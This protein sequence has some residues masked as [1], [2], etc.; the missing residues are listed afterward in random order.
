M[1]RLSKFNF[2]DYIVF[3]TL[4]CTLF[5]VIVTK[6]PPG[7]GSV[8]FFWG[9]LTIITLLLFANSIYSVSPVKQLMLFGFVVMLLFNMIFWRNLS[10]WNR[11][12]FL[13]DF[14]NIF[15]YTII[16]SYY[17]RS[18]KVEN[19]YLISKISFIYIIITAIMTNIGLFFDPLIIRDSA[20]GF[21]TNVRQKEIYNLYGT[22]RYGYAQA[23][24]L[25][26]PFCFYSLK[27]NKNSNVNK[28]IMSVCIA[29]I[30]ITTLRSQVF[31]NIINLVFVFIFS[32]ISIEK[33]KSMVLLITPV[34]LIVIILPKTIYSDI[35][36]SFTRYFSEDSNTFLKLNDF[37]D[38]FIDPEI[39]MST[40]TGGRAAR[41]PLLWEAFLQSP[42]VGHS[43]LDKG[44]DIE[45]GGHLFWMNRL[46]HFGLIGFSMLVHSLYTTFKT[47]KRNII[48]NEGVYYYFLSIMSFLLFGLMKNIAGREIWAI[49]LVVIPGLYLR[50][51]R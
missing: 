48:K 34:V 43:Y 22:A 30:V 45:A 13:D 29:L 36:R 40:G 27:H 9:P 42:I 18:K 10:D 33:R 14:Y 31:A 38:F 16:I 11:R 28:R 23:F 41:Y 46:A 21:G 26:I 2:I 44:L 37:A 32:I 8:R 12:N 20:V 35:I 51:K 17:I 25:L 49:I 6:L 3:A 50:K 47:I 1:T 5:N 39:D 4:T 19:L 15:L 24:V 7:I